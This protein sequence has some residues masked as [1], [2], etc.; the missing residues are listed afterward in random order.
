MAFSLILG[1]LAGCGDGVDQD[2][3]VNDGQKNDEMD[4]KNTEEG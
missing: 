3:G 2:N 4:E 1:G